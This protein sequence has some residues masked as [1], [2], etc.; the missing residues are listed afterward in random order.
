MNLKKV[1][2]MELKCCLATWQEDINQ[3]PKTPNTLYHL[4][5][6]TKG[7]VASPLEEAQEQRGTEGH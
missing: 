4:I 2:Q 1:G 7:L 5:K 3:D 6:S